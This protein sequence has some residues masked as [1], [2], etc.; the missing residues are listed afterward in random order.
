MYI[1]VSTQGTVLNFNLLPEGSFM[2]IL[3]VKVVPDSLRLQSQVLV[4]VQ[5]WG[6]S[7]IKSHCSVDLFLSFLYVF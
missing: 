5:P 3:Y 7:S 4:V 6:H 2:G 1:H